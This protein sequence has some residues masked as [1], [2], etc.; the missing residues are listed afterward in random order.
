MMKML[1]DAKPNRFEDMTL[2]NTYKSDDIKTKNNQVVTN[3][4]DNAIVSENNKLESNCWDLMDKEAP[5]LDKIDSHNPEELTMGRV[6]FKKHN[7]QRLNKFSEEKYGDESYFYVALNDLVE[8]NLDKIDAIRY[9]DAFQYIKCE[10]L[11][12]R[13]DVLKKLLEII[14]QLRW[15]N[16]NL[17][18]ISK[19]IQIIKD[20][21]IKD[22]RTIEK[23]RKCMVEFSIYRNQISF[24]HG[25]LNMTGFYEGVLDLIKKWEDRK[26]IGNNENFIQKSSNKGIGVAPTIQNAVNEANTQNNAM[27]DFRIIYPSKEIFQNAIKMGIKPNSNNKGI[28]KNAIH[29]TEEITTNIAI[30]PKKVDI[31]LGCTQNPIPYNAKGAK[32]LLDHI[33]LI[34]NLLSKTYQTDN[35]IDPLELIVFYYHLNQDGTTKLSKEKL[36]RTTTDNSGEKTRDYAKTFDDCTRRMRIEQTITDRIPLGE[37]LSDMKRCES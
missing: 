27:H 7:I 21:G 11:T 9:E 14:K 37:L 16:V 33:V 18:T 5:L 15:D 25:Q 31:T 22:L 10:G 34:N 4:I 13:I 24:A 8:E 17:I 32:Q 12:P 1:Q 35:N 36:C 3:L 19:V 28:F 6:Y 2:H 29:V 20:L 30:Y 23:Y 26:N